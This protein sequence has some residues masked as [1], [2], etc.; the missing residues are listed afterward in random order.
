MYSFGSREDELVDTSK[1]KALNHF[2]EIERYKIKSVKER[3][4]N[5][6]NYLR[7]LDANI[8]KN[9]KILKENKQEFNRAEG[10]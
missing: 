8:K 1:E 5:R 9:E 2:I 6:R 10:G 7:Y 4:G 3:F